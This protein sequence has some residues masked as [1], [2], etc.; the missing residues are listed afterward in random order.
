M[1]EKIYKNF[2]EEN[3]CKKRKLR[4]KCFSHQ[5]LRNRQHREKFSHSLRKSDRE[6][7]EEIFLFLKKLW[8]WSKNNANLF[9]FT[10]KFSTFLSDFLWK[11]SLK[12]DY[13]SIKSWKLIA[14][15]CFPMNILPVFILVRFWRLISHFEREL[16]IFHLKSS[17]KLNSNLLKSHLTL[18]F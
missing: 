3:S 10:G 2:R 7:E 18:N 5:N 13:A 11:F 15:C 14:T 16:F 12:F 4:W 8:M 1:F 6:K 9:F 17:L